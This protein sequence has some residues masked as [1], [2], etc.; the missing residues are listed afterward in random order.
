MDKEQAEQLLE[1][2]AKILVELR[3]LRATVEGKTSAAT[4][5][6]GRGIA[7]IVTILDAPVAWKSGGGARYWA[8]I[9]RDDAGGASRKGSFMMR[10]EGSLRYTQGDVVR[11]TGKLE[12]EIRDG[13]ER[14]TFWADDA[15]LVDNSEQ[16]PDEGLADVPASA[17]A[18]DAVDDEDVPF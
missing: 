15:Q 8:E 4:T 3:K 2:T 9:A 10:G 6:P 1:Y 18:T 13:K 11:A 12:T 5:N 17:P 16:A 14:I 7:A